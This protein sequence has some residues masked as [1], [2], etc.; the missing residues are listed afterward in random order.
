MPFSAASKS[1]PAFFFVSFVLLSF[2]ILRAASLT[3]L[4]CSSDKTNWFLRWV[5]LRSARCSIVGG[6]FL[7]C[8]ACAGSD[9][10]NVAKAMR[11]QINFSWLLLFFMICCVEMCFL[12]DGLTVLAFSFYGGFAST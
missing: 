10:D 7:S 2:S 5:A 9:T 1:S 12:K 6:A 11:M 8:C 3:W 4:Y